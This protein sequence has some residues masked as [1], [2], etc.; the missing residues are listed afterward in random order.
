MRFLRDD[1]ERPDAFALNI[2]KNQRAVD[3]VRPD[4][5]LRRR[6][7]HKQVQL[8]VRLFHR[9][10][11]GMG[12]HF[13]RGGK[14][15]GRRRVF[16]VVRFQNQR[17][18][19]F[20]KRR[21]PP[22]FRQPRRHARDLFVWRAA[23]PR[24][25]QSVQIARHGD[26]FAE[27]SQ[28]RRFG[29]NAIY[30]ARRQ[31]FGRFDLYQHERAAAV[32]V[33]GERPRG[34]F[35]RCRPITPRFRK[36]VRQLQPQFDGFARVARVFPINVPAARQ[37]KLQRQ[38]EFAARFDRFAAGQQFGANGRFGLRPRR[39]GKKEKGKNI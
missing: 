6:F 4:V 38:P 7:F 19:R 15:I 22:C 36:T 27:T 1:V 5:F 25:H 18:R 23:R 29:R 37:I 8:A 17:V 34:K 10:G 16:I 3:R 21:A 9:L 20:K 2:V 11:R 12:Q 35:F 33:F 30:F 31:V 13:R 26:A 39:D 24:D 14:E 28:P 32:P